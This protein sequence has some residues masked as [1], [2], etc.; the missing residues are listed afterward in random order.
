MAIAALFVVRYNVVGHSFIVMAIR[1]LDLM[2]L[3]ASVFLLATIC[4]QRED[5][6]FSDLG[7][8]YSLYIYIFHMLIMSICEML[9]AKLPSNMCDFYMYINPICVF[10]LSI[11]VTYVLGELKILKV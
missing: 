11:I 6:L 4:V 3:T 10:L 5:N 8:R 1:E 7:R 9:A 2:L